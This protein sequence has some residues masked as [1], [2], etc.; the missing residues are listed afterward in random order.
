MQT[1]GYPYQ[2]LATNR[3]LGLE[4]IEVKLVV[5]CETLYKPL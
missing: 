3:L 2:V 1:R 4:K 5:Q